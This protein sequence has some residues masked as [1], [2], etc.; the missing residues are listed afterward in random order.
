MEG[1][2]GSLKSVSLTV[3]IIEAMSGYAFGMLPVDAYISGFAKKIDESVGGFSKAL[4]EINVYIQ[5]LKT[6]HPHLIE[7]YE[8]MPMFLKRLEEN[9]CYLRK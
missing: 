7:H 5:D 4:D 8:D 1:Q 3:N 9:M 6:K 2:E